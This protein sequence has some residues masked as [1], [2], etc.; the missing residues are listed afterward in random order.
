[1]KRCPACRRV[2]ADESLRFCRVCGSPLGGE[3]T[4]HD[5][6][7][8]TL[9]KLPTRAGEEGPTEIL[10][11][12]ASASASTSS[13]LTRQLSPARR[14]RAALKRPIDSL[15]ALPPPN[16]ADDPQAE[17]LSAGITETI[18]NPLPQLPNWPAFPR[19]SDFGYNGRASDPLHAAP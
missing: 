1:M 16:G 2:Y 3:A 18:L 19:P 14:R 4:A 11:D 17:Y 12:S 13:Q 9:F 8:A 7:S 10:G 15:A 6:A 5:D